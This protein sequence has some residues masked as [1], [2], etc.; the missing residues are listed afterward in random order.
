[1]SQE[2]LR[3][4]GLNGFETAAVDAVTAEKLAGYDVVLLGDVAVTPAQASLLSSWVSGGGNLVA[5]S[6]DPALDALLGI[7]PEGASLSNAYLRVNTAQPPGAGIVDENDPVPRHREPSTP[8]RARQPS[9]RCTRPPRRRPR[10]RPSRCAASVRSGGEAAAFAFDVARSV[11]ASPARATRPGSAS[12][13]DG[14][15]DTPN[16]TGMFRTN[17]LFYGGDEP[18]HE[19]DWVDLAKIDVPQAD[20]LQRLLANVITHMNRDRTAGAAVLVPAQRRE[21]GRRDDRRRPLRGRDRGRDRRAP[22]PLHGREP[23]RL[24]R[25]PV[26]VRALHGLHLR[27][28][29]ACHRR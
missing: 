16:G 10:T 4:E 8:S 29:P 23:A 25:R 9:R 19:P 13:R 7:A 18:G 1:M 28:A 2:I 21:R 22:R 17:D 26:A 24:L 3:A 5:L 11:V 15:H 14:D 27:P 6:P 20:E 12:N